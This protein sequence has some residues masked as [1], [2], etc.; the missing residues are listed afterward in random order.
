MA[1]LA[2]AECTSSLATESSTQ[3]TG[4]SSSAASNGASLDRA[5]LGNSTS[6]T[7]AVA[8]DQNQNIS[9]YENRKRAA[10]RD[11]NFKDRAVSAAG[12][13][14]VSA[15][16]VNP[17]DVAKIF[18][19]GKCPP[20]C[21]RG[22]TAGVVPLCPPDCFRYKGTLDVF[23]KVVRQEGY[24]RLWRG[25]NAAL[26]IAIPTVGIY[27]PCYD[28]LKESLERV[29]ERNSFNIKPYAPLLAG[30]VARS[31]ACIACAPM[32]LARTRMQAQKEIRF[33]VRPPGI[34][35]TLTGALSAGNEQALRHS[36]RVRILWTG[37]GAQLARDVPFSAI[38]WTTLEPIRGYLLEEWNLKKNAAGILAANIS[39]GWAA[40]SIA[41]AATCPLDVAKTRRQIEKD[42]Q[43]AL[44]ASTRQLLARVWREEGLRG[45][46]GGVV[47]RVARAGPSVGIV[48]SFYELLKYYV[49]HQAE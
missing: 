19:D 11:M 21:P 32:E 20:V 48:V 45:L 22:G 38:C 13:A 43:K 25:T 41:A 26:A 5:A 9:T 29:S 10:E 23:Y 7:L 2:R 16:L 27:L 4:K 49:N 33:G 42:P 34:W 40:G 30:S 17:L 37:V 14:F 24:L 15:I 18:A 8:R 6:Q 35:D 31:L 47:P 39:A 46:F 1:C 12:A 36:Q 3:F 44:S 28:V